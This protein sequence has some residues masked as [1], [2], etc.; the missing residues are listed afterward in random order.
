MSSAFYCSFCGKA[1]TETELMLSG[2]WPIFMCIECVD[3]AHK[4]A[5]AALASR[6]ADEQ[7]FADA[8]RCAFCIPFPIASPLRVLDQ[9][10]TG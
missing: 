6:K 4:Q 9:Q 7:F 3:D 8:R 1:N 10:E 2:P 5:H